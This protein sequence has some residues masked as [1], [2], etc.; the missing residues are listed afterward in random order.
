MLLEVDDVAVTF[1]PP[2][3]SATLAVRGVSFGL[4][5]GETLGIVGESGCGKSVTA[6]SLLRLIDPPGRIERGRVLLDGENLLALPER[7]LRQIRG[8][9]IA[10]APQDPLTSLNPVMTIGAQMVETIR[11]HRRL[12]ARDARRE[13]VHWL[14]RV[15]IPSAAQRMRQYPYEMSGGM[16]QRVMLAMAFSLRPQVL[17]ADEPTTALDMTVQAQILNLMDELKAEQGTSVLLI[18][19][20]LGIVAE[21]ADRVVVM[22]GGQIVESAAAGD[23]F[24][25]ARHPYTQALLASAP[26]PRRSARGPLPFLDGQP[27]RISAGEPKA[28]AFAPRCARRFDACLRVEPE[29][30]PRGNEAQPVRCLLYSQSEGER[31]Q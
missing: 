15:R 14:D 10:W 20:D 9:K 31:A 30:L 3:R 23:I 25:R 27:P 11:A 4:E 16:R 6:L 29:L 2:G 7:R 28:C 8:A 1:A 21:R 12:S 24:A 18:T 5:R 19:H 26:D 22:Y 17:I 13:A